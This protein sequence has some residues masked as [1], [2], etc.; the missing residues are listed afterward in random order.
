MP[1]NKAKSEIR[2][3]LRRRIGLLT[4]SERKHAAEAASGVVWRLPIWR[5]SASLLAYRAFGKELDADGVIERALADGKRV[6]V[7]RVEESGIRFLRIGSLDDP[8]STGSFGI[9]EPVEGTEPW[10]PTSWPN[11]VLVLVPGL[12]FTPDGRRIGRGGGY[13]D[14]FLARARSV[15]PG[16]L[17]ALGFGYD[18]QVVDSL[19]AE[20]EDASMDALVTERGIRFSR[21]DVPPRGAVS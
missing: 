2:K 21:L 10:D 15:I 12:G 14:R 1:S 5:E 9:R 17:F 20:P 6:A 19:P 4:L 8:W 11:P 3:N 7:P 16:K 18:V 13:Y